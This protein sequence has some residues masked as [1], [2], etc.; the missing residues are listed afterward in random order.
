[1][2]AKG[3]PVPMDVMDTPVCRFAIVSDPDGN[4]LMLHK[5]KAK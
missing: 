1:L 3:V 2:K 5:R 4:R